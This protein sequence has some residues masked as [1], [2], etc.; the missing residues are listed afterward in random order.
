MLLLLINLIA[1]TESP[2]EEPDHLPVELSSYD[3]LAI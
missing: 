2:I 1:R 3:K